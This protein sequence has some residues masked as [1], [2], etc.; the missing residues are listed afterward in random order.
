MVDDTVGQLKAWADAMSCL[1]VKSVGKAFKVLE[2]FSE[3]ERLLSLGEI[4]TR[5]GIDKSAVQRITYTL[6]KLGYLDHDPASRRYMLAI[7]VLD[8]AFGYL[9]SHPLIE[10]AA[11]ILLDLR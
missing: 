6:Q 11:P 10:K 7:H 8:H 3:R 4:A 1:E 9:R 2:V 5:T